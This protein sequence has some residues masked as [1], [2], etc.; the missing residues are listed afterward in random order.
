M[1]QGKLVKNKK[2]SIMHKSK[3]IIYIF[4]VSPLTGGSRTMYLINANLRF[5]ICIMELIIPT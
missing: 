4:S 2:R 3:N 5:L 1:Y